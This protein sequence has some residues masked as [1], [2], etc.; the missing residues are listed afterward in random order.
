[1]TTG[2]IVVCT[3]VYIPMTI[4]SIDGDS[5]LCTFFIGDNVK[6]ETH[7]L[8]D[9]TVITEDEAAE[10]TKERERDEF[11]QALKDRAKELSDA[12]GGAKVIP[13]W[14][15]DVNNPDSKPIIGFLKE[16]NRVTKGSI[17]DIYNIS[18]SRAQ[19]AALAASIMKDVSD[20]R[21]MSTSQRYDYVN[22]AAGKK[23]LT[24]ITLAVEQFKKK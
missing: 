15:L 10:L 12:N 17:M 11:E 5:A 22:M 24:L 2:D 8:A 7:P 19:T 21:I 20:E 1:M 4:K 6:E 18:E 16:P 13:L 3:G 9:L 14:Y 23:A